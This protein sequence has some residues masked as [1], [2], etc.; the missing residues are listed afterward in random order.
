[1]QQVTIYDHVFHF[2]SIEQVNG[3]NI[4]TTG[5]NT[6]VYYIDNYYHREDGPAIEHA[7][8][9]CEYWLNGVK[10]EVKPICKTKRAE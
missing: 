3:V 1:M 9:S 4:G 5:E 8:G 7:D 6:K 2:V 10:Q